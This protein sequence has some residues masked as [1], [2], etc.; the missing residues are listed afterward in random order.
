MMRREELSAQ[1]EVEWRDRLARQASS[2]KNIAAFCRGEGVT[3]SAFYGWRSRLGLK[4]ANHEEPDAAI[5]MPL[6]FI[7]IGPVK[8]VA[9][10]NDSS[11][12]DKNDLDTEPLSS[13]ELRLELGN[14]VVLQITRR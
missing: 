1:L 6:P 5:K 7:D 11:T 10:S 13:L 4:Y 3:E 8:R 9:K 2:G 14:G 12:V